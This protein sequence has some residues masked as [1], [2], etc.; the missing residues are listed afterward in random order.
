MKGF[1]LQSWEKGDII[2]ENFFHSNFLIFSFI[3]TQILGITEALGKQC[4][5][6]NYTLPAQGSPIP[7]CAHTCIRLSNFY[8]LSSSGQLAVVPVN[9]LSVSIIQPVRFRSSQEIQA[10]KNLFHP[11][12][13]ELMT[14]E[15]FAYF[16]LS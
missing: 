8:D 1:F 9:S 10:L 2:V 3:P 13:W 4:V 16:R 11:D 6:D 5:C 15:N 14:M 12:K 7:K